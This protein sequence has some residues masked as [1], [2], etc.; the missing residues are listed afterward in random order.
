MTPELLQSL[1]EKGILGLLLVIALVAIFFL[2]KETK[3]ERN[4]RLT[5]M[6]DVWQKDVEYRAELKNL[7]QSIL[8]ILRVKK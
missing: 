8:D 6:K 3:I 5:D 2:Y 7:I 1:A 4:D